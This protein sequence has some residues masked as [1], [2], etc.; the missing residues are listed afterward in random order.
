MN[1]AHQ[2]SDAAP[3]PYSCQLPASGTMH[4]EALTVRPASIADVRAMVDCDTYA[5]SHADRRDFILSAV[6]QGQCLLAVAAGGAIGFVVLT[7]D[8]FGEGFIPLIVVTPLHRR[9]GIAL[10]LLAAAETACGT[11]KLFASTNVSNV[12]AQALLAKAGFVRSGTIDN[13][14]EDGPELVYFKSVR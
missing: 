10:Q 13:L 7:H 11:T 4:V 12:P 1:A 5:I 14:D 9:K 3:M 2:P 6:K 8:F